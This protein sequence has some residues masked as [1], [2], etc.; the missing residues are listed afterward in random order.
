MAESG[1][2]QDASPRITGVVLEALKSR[3]NSYLHID[4]GGEELWV[5]TPRVAVS[6]GDSVTMPEGARVIDFYSAPL[7]R[8]FDS[9]VFVGTIE[10]AG[11]E[12]SP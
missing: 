3:N 1:P 2:K 5:A 12:N 7:D 6:A 4:T 9:I 8:R 11:G 10:V